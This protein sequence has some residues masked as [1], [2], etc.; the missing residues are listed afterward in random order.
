VRAGPEGV[1]IPWTKSVAM[2]QLDTSA[3]IGSF[4]GAKLF[5]PDL[6]ALIESGERLAIS[7]LVLYEWL[8]GPRTPR[9]LA[10]QE[11][12]LPVQSAIPFDAQDA[13]SAAEIYRSLPRASNREIDIAIAAVAIRHEAP[14]W[15]L[16]PRDFEDIPRLRLFRPAR[17]LR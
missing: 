8:R 6:N 15:T 3:L 2:I 10:I 17:R 12:L 16:N 9:E 13:Q 11:E 7:S 4:T 1:C 5:S 14:L